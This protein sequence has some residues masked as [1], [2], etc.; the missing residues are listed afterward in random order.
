MA[1]KDKDGNWVDPRGRT[2]PPSFIQPLV[3]KRDSVVE[4]SVRAAL[5]LEKRMKETKRKIMGWIAD[6]INKMVDDL[7]APRSGKGNIILTGFSGDKQ[8][9]FRIN[10]V[11]TLDEKLQVAKSKI[12][13]C[14][15]RWSKDAHRNL[16]VIIE[17]AF[18]VDKH[19]NVDTRRILGLRKLKIRDKRWN[20]AMDLIADSIDITGT[21]EYLKIKTR[22]HSTDKFRNINLN[23][24]SINLDD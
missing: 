20:E 6:Y 16:R 8:I 19:G 21:R 1:N 22:K 18:Q 23:F 7:G 2:V 5:T 9:E 14:L 17:Q 4:Q 12:D 24:S 10:D 3:R 11:I 15:I 13:E